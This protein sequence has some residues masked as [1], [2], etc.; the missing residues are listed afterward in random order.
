M[1]LDGEFVVSHQCSLSPDVILG[2]KDITVFLLRTEGT[3][4]LSSPFFQIIFSCTMSTMVCCPISGSLKFP[5]T[6]GEG[7]RQC[8]PAFHIGTVYLRLCQYKKP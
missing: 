7:P 1:V 6:N 3:F 4:L 5:S 2:Q 8:F